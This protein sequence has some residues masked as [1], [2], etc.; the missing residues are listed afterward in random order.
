MLREMA[1]VTES[2]VQPLPQYPPTI[3]QQPPPSTP[4]PQVPPSPEPRRGQR[5]ADTYRESRVGG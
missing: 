5:G 2:N 1:L 4:L 3:R